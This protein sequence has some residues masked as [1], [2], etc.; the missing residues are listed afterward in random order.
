MPAFQVARS[1]LVDAPPNRVFDTVVDFSTW[2]TW[3]P[4]LGIE[5]DANVTV[6]AVSNQVGSTYDWAGEVVGSGGMCHTHLATPTSSTAGSIK[7][8]LSFIKPFKSQSKVEFDI[9]PIDGKTELTWHMHGKLPWFLFWMK[10]G[11]EKFIGM[12]YRRGL[13]M[14]R[15]LIETDRVTSK[16]EVKGVESVKASTVVGLSGHCQFDDLSDKLDAAFGEAIKQKPASADANAMVS[17]YQATSDLKAGTCD[18]TAGFE[19]PMNT[20]APNEFEIRALRE[21][22]YLCLRH[23][24]SYEHLGNA[25]SGAY[26][27][28]RYKKLKLAKGVD[29]FGRYRNCPD[30]VD[31]SEL[32][33]DI[34]LPLRG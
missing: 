20:P 30:D 3:S 4:W 15:E 27:Y 10:P 23:T 11:I 22:P 18:Y 5:P 25:W 21:G 16:I 14:V 9:K 13:L 34:Y 6:S 1:I 29:S 17:I 31:R 32:I 24:G 33:T 12:D 8:D 28:A 7:S 19:V 2:T 26:Q